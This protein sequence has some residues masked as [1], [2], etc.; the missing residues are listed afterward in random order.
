MIYTLY[1]QVPFLEPKRTGQ[2]LTRRQDAP[3][4]RQSNDLPT[5]KAAISG[6]PVLATGQVGHYLRAW[7]RAG[8]SGALTV[9]R[10]LHAGRP[11]QIDFNLGC[12]RE[13]NNQK[14]VGVGPLQG[15]CQPPPPGCRAFASYHAARKV[16]RKKDC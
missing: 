1:L 8:L 15:P 6:P 9:D 13:S 10:A 7:Y 2:I 12:G 14:A 5:N 11:S 3:T 16:A 4:F